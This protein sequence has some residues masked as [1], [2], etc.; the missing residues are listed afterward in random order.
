MLNNFLL[1]ALNSDG[2]LVTGPTNSNNSSG[3]NTNL[4]SSSQPGLVQLAGDLSNTAAS[5]KV[6]G[7]QGNAVSASTPS[8]NNVLTWNGSAWAPTAP[9]TYVS[10]PGSST[11]GDI[12]LFNNTTGTLLSDSGKA[13]PSGTI[14]GTT[15]TQTLTNKQLTPRVVTLTVSSNTYTPNCGTTDTALISSPTANFTIA[16]PTGTPVDGQSLIIRILS[17]TTAYTASY[18]TIYLSSGIATLPT[19]M[20]ISKT[21]TL[22]LQYNAAKTKWVLLAVDSTGY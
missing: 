5:P 22:G 17:G 2:T 16:N 11:S 1:Q 9:T 21:V 20:V 7:L 19:A 10:G 14:V 8:T 15:D 18:G 3:I 13:V 4:A 12:A 6:A